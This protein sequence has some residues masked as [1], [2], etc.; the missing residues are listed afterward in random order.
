MRRPS[1]RTPWVVG[2]RSEGGR[3]WGNGADGRRGRCAEAP[4]VEAAVGHR[5]AGGRPSCSSPAWRRRSPTHGGPGSVPRPVTRCGRTRRP[6]AS[7]LTG[8]SRARPATRTPACA[9]RWR[10]NGRGPGAWCA[11]SAASARRARRRRRDDDALPA[12]PCQPS[13]A[14][15]AG[16]RQAGHGRLRS[17]A[18]RAGGLRRLS[19]PHGASRN[20][21]PGRRPAGDHAGLFRLSHRHRGLRELPLLSRGEA[22]GPR[23]LSGLPRAHRL[24][25]RPPLPSSGHARQG[26]RGR[27]VRGLPQ[28]RLRQGR[29]S[30]A[31]RRLSQAGAR[32]THRLRRLPSAVGL[33]AT[34]LPPSCC[35]RPRRRRME[36]AVLPELPSGR[37]VRDRLVP[38]PYAARRPP[39]ARGRSSLARLRQLSCRRGRRRGALQRVPRR[40][41]PPAHGLRSLSRACVLARHG[42]RTSGRRPAPEPATGGS[43]A[44]ACHPSGYGRASLQLSRLTPLLRQPRPL[45]LRRRRGPPA[46]SVGG[47]SAPLTEP[48]R[49]V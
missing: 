21:R 4:V 28:P 15:A 19:H 39:A 27:Q 17:S 44:A 13:L 31:L 14:P 22:S 8:T 23:P 40:A 33:A 24:A 2:N 46:T 20:G 1:A 16:A 9:T 41:A 47:P 35:R 18:A 38:L 12:L 36:Q 30:P 10:R 42:F 6:C 7:R 5:H 49:S 29:Q 43:P 48:S 11:T 3:R 37:R 25:Q 32:R 45:P 26:P 34:H